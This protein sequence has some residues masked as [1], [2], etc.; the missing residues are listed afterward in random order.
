MQSIKTKSILSLE[1]TIAKELFESYEYPWQVLPLIGEYI[2]RIAENLSS[3]EY[4]NP[5]ENVWI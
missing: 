5:S 3:E 4:D 1:N 2:T